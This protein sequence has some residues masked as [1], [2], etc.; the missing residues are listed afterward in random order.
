METIEWSDFE[1][2]SLVVGTILEVESF[3]E[4]RKPAYK[5]TLDLGPKIGIKRSSAQITKLYK[6][7]ELIGKQVLC[8]VNFKPKQIGNFLSEV[9][10]TGFIQEDGVVL[11]VPER[12]VLNGTPLL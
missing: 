3:P 1:K 5:L 7:E 8:V 11:A 4:A 2:V 6:S 10:V 12:R 9:L